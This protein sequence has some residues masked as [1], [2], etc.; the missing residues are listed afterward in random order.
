[1]LDNPLIKGEILRI[2]WPD[3]MKWLYSSPTLVEHG[4]Y[5]FPLQTSKGVETPGDHPPQGEW[6]KGA[7][8]GVGTRD[9]NQ[10]F[11]ETDIIFEQ[12][13]PAQ[14]PWFFSIQK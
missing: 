5:R 12:D 9:V 8:S 7:I 1:M 13:I 6:L 2:T 11:E 3:N 14:M 10:K 4:N